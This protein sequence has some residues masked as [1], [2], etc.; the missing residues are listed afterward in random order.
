M[1]RF[2]DI[3]SHF[4][5]RVSIVMGKPVTFILALAGVGAWAASGPAFG[6]SDIWQL[7]IN[8]TTTIVTFLMIFIL[9]NSQNRDGK[10]LQAKLD[11][12]ILT[13]KARNRFVGIEKLDERQLELLHRLIERQARRDR[14]PGKAASDAA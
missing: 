3:F 9:Q 4:A 12:L 14:G 2:S 8:T 1:R 6:Y 7:L 10:A 5:A 11:E 13:S